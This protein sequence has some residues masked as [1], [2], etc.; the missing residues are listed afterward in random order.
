MLGNI[1]VSI[2][3]HAVIALE[4]CNRSSSKREFCVAGNIGNA[5]A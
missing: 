2:R 1:M 5:A 3:A 4:A